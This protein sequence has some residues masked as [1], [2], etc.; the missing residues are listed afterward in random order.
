MR[1]SSVLALVVAV[2]LLAGLVTEVTAQCPTART[3]RSAGRPGNA[4]VIDVADLDPGSNEIGRFWDSEDATISHNG[5]EGPDF[6]NLCP[7]EHWWKPRE[8]NGYWCIDGAL[9]AAGCPQHG[10]PSRELTVVIEDYDQNGPPGIDGTAHYI[11]W[12]TDETPA[13]DRWFDFGG[14]DGVTERTILPMLPFPELR[15]TGS[16]RHG[17]IIQVSADL[18]DQSDHVHTW[19]WEQ[20]TPYPTSDLIL[21]WQV[22]RHVGNWDPGRLR[23]SGWEKLSVIQYFPGGAPTEFNATCLHH[24]DDEFYAMGIGF[25][26]GNGQVIDS[27]LVGRAIYLECDP[28][29]ADPDPSE[30][31]DRKPSATQLKGPG[32]SGGRR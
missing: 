6:G 22:L 9:T 11:A 29:M 21:E 7:P 19:N 17:S 4:V 20:G 23:S 3:F 14:V 32:R 30:E 16:S 18:P 13:S 12:K 5:L 28:N 31:L 1:R 27:A 10:C 8:L 25:N 15:I 24:L 2:L 26:G